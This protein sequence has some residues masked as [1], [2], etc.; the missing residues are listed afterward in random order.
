MLCRGMRTLVA[1][2][3]LV[4]ALT[5][6]SGAATGTS[7]AQ[8][9]AHL[10]AFD[11][12]LGNLQVDLT[13][14]V[15]VSTPAEIRQR[16]NGLGSLID[17]TI[18]NI[19]QGFPSVSS[20]TMLGQAKEITTALAAASKFAGAA[21]LRALT[22]AGNAEATLE[23]EAAAAAAVPGGADPLA[24]VRGTTS[25][26]V[27]AIGT[28][29][30]RRLLFDNTLATPVAISSVLVAGTGFQDVMDS[31]NGATLA[32]LATCRVTIAFSPFGRPCHGDTQREG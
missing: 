19:S 25:F 2:V 12:S 24:M 7:A 14:P 11:E 22:R 13:A 8:A 21:Q 4:G 16:L 27:Q 15:V 20:A 29:M 9:L 1:L 26:G 31:C 23:A 10:Q 18:P 6:S 28:L 32:P 17:E 3:L 30:S 5:G